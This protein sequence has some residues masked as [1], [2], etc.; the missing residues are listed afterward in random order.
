MAFRRKQA[1]PRPGLVIVGL[2]NP[3]REY[4]GTRHNLGF[5]AADEV[6]RR[7]GTR[8]TQRDSRALVGAAQPPGDGPS[9]LL[10][11]PQTFMNL[12]GQAV[13]KLLRKHQLGP[14][15]TWVLHDEMD[16]AFGRLRIRKGGGPGGH[17]GVRSLI[18]DLGTQEF[19]RFRMGV[20][21]PAGEEDPVDHLLEPFTADERARVPALVELT[22]NAVM[23]ALSDG[24]DVSM[25]RHNGSSV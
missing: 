18:A 17:N 2:G 4:A 10:V 16:I 15:D 5:L 9:V 24:I 14:G 21:R 11:K 3:G 12:S 6:A 7:L 25:N 22:A 1:E 8:I 19:S 23:D 13:A 20:G